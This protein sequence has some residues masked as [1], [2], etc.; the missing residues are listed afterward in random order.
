VLVVSCP[1]ALSLA[2]PAVIA[3][4]T[5]ALARRQVVVV[6]PDALETLARVDVV[7]FDKTGT[8]THGTPTIV[9][10]VSLR[11]TPRDDALR[12]AAALEQASEHPLARALRSG[13][14]RVPP[15]RDVTMHP[16]EGI[17]GDVDGMR[18]RIG[19][20]SFVT[21]RTGADAGVADAIASLPT[22]RTVVALGNDHGVVAIF[23]CADAA[24][25]GARACVAALHAARVG[26]VMLSG[27]R[28]SA[29]GALAASLGIDDVRAG[30]APADKCRAIGALQRDR[31]RVAMIGDGVNDAAALAQADVAISLGSATPLA[32]CSSDIVLLG[33]RLADVPRA[34]R[35]ARKVGRIIAQNLA[36]AAAYNAVALPA[37]AAGLVTPLLASIGMSVSSL[38]VVLNAVRAARLAPDPLADAPAAEPWPDAVP[39]P[40]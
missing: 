4:G 18:W 21:E 29:A 19:A 33:E 24:R 8:L 38:V 5:A 35:H 34:I 31:H 28:A 9:D 17:E 10:H 27:D 16:G 22:G 20:P 7:A 23:G 36:W 2:T 12:I 13:S 11:G 1:C 6:G 25:P 32:Q 3:A 14:V 40:A 37:A 30:L 26:T 39:R 15:A